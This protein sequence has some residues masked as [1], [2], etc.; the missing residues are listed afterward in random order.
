MP[1]EMI[2]LL[3][4]VYVTRVFLVQSVYSTK[5][6]RILATSP[7]NPHFMPFSFVAS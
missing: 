1:H 7:L 2:F 6:G 5:D 3:S 4:G